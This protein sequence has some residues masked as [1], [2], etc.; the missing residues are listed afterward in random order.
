M[1]LQN[2]NRTELTEWQKRINRFA[3]AA[4]GKTRL[5]KR[6]QIGHERIEV[7]SAS[8]FLPGKTIRIGGVA[9]EVKAVCFDIE[10]QDDDGV[11]DE[12]V[13]QSKLEKKIPAGQIT[14]WHQTLW[15]FQD[16]SKAKPPYV[17]FSTIDL[18]SRGIPYKE[19]TTKDLGKG[20]KLAIVTEYRGSI[21]ATFV[22]PE[23]IFAAQQFR[24][25]L[26]HPTVS[27]AIGKVSLYRPNGL[28]DQSTIESADYHYA[29]REDYNIAFK[30]RRVFP[31]PVYPIEK[32]TA[33]AEID[34]GNVTV[35]SKVSLE[36]LND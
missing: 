5:R 8:G 17:R 20:Y 15:S 2:D 35:E 1:S 33:T 11:H 27:R 14:R 23:R 18:D 9:A 28:A 16:A 3:A 12:I 19:K 31:A 25:A 34:P 6:A 22:G 24:Q 26:G 32:V 10:N 21:R 4:L 36:E 30:E 29:T 7:D 13:L